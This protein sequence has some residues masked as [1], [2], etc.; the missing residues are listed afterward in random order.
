VATEP[1][2]APAALDE[3]QLTWG[4]QV[5]N[6]AVSP[7]SGRD[8]RVAILDTGLDLG[9]PDFTG[10][11]ITAQSFIQGESAQDGHGHGT[12]VAG[13]ACGSKQ[14]G[15]L[16]RY[17][18]AYEAEIFIG[19]VLSN[20]GS[21]TD[22]GI[23]AGINWAIANQCAVINMSLGAATVPGQSFSRV[24][25]TVAQRALARGALIIAA[26][27]NESAR[28]GRV[29]PVGHPANCPSIIAVGAVDSDLRTAFFSCCG[30]NP[31]GG[32][33]DIAA[34]GVDIRS[35]WP[36][37]ALYRTIKGTSMATP[38]V[39]GIAALHIQAHKGTMV[40]GSLGWLLMQSSRRLDLP[41]LDVGVGLVQAP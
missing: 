32:Q 34:P 29:A 30:I 1:V 25:E 33:V 27:G 38:H 19:K 16:P 40:G 22:G 15:Q 17:G 21:G 13:T 11:Q 31:Q 20:Q 23:L 7:F 3:S 10:R 37:Q 41:A 6:V 28:P 2:A 8:V 12:H 9:H 35:S 4:L 26:A 5:T 39:T 36:R 14:P 18:I 24:F